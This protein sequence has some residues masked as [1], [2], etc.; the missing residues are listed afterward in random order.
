MDI[1]DNAMPREIISIDSDDSE[2]EQDDVILSSDSEGPDDRRSPFYVDLSTSDADVPAANL[3]GIENAHTNVEPSYVASEAEA[4]AIDPE[5]LYADCLNR[6]LEIFPDICRDHARNLYDSQMAI[7]G[8]QPLAG[9]DGP[10]SVAII[11]QILESKDEYP[12]ET[13][14][15]KKKKRKRSLI[16][17]SPEDEDDHERW[18]SKS[19][20]KLTIP[21]ALDAYVY[22][23]FPVDSMPMCNTLVPPV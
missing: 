23:P 7:L 1:Q 20:P 2:D 13:A 14:K 8:T 18:R 17:D 6:V 3:F 9:S 11:Q 5:S 4:V 16:E 21:E 12:K 10:L 15:K 19:R 22:I